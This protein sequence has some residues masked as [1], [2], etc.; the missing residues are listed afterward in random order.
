MTVFS[1][2]EKVNSEKLEKEIKALPGI[3]KM[4]HTPEVYVDI[5]DKK[6][7]ELFKSMNLIPTL[8]FLDPWGYKGLTIDLIQSLIKDWG[9]ECI[10]FF[11]YNRINIGIKNDL[12]L[13][14]GSF[15]SLPDE[16]TGAIADLEDTRCG[17]S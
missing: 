4:V 14:K 5:V 10:I 6:M 9:S 16:W 12:V 8:T 3:N 7:A 17:S 15:S 13:E 1:D 2:M 11:N